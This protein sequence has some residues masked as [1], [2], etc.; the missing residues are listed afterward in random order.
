MLLSAGMLQ[1]KVQLTPA[2][3][4]KRTRSPFPPDGIRR[5]HRGSIRRSN[6]V[7]SNGYAF[8]PRRCAGGFMGAPC[9]RSASARARSAG[10][11]STG[12]RTMSWDPPEQNPSP[13]RRNTSTCIAIHCGTCP[14]RYSNPPR[15]IRRHASCPPDWDPWN[16]RVQPESASF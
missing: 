1:C 16:P 4:R 2:R 12:I 7:P 13:A 11:Q 10:A 9:H 15:S 14:R 3:G 6:H 5:R 8:R